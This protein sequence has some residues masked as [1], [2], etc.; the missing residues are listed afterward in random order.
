MT[1]ESLSRL[2]ALDRL[3]EAV[4]MALEHRT[5]WIEQQL[6]YET[7]EQLEDK[8]TNFFERWLPALPPLERLQAAAWVGGHYVLSLVHLEDARRKGALFVLSAQEAAV[9]AVADTMRSIGT[10]ADGPD[11]MLHPSVE[12][13][14]EGYAEQLDDMSFEFVPF[15]PED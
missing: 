11:A 7:L 15:D 9:A 12:Q 2:I 1:Q 3:D 10:F 4:L 14:L 13:R 8:A 6:D 5:V